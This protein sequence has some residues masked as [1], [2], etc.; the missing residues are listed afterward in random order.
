MEKHGLA[1]CEF[2]NKL[3][4][5]YEVQHYTLCDGWKNTWTTYRNDREVPTTFH[6]YEDALNSLEGFL[7]DEEE[8]FDQGEID[9]MYSRDEFRIVQTEVQDEFDR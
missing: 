9:S 8:A 7:M 2:N 4:G 6:T 5:L 3:R 1:V